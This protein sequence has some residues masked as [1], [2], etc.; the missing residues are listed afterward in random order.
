MG[1]IGFSAFKGD[2]LKKE[3]YRL[4]SDKGKSHLT[5]WEINTDYHLGV[6]QEK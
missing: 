5:N 1:V 3:V 4:I 6:G 2:F